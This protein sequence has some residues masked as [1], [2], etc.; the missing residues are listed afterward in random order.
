MTLGGQLV[1]VY[2]MVVYTVDLVYPDGNTC[3]T[4]VGAGREIA[5]TGQMV[6]YKL[7]VWVVIDPMGQLVTVGG[8]LVMV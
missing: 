5:D 2:M 8:H 7:M 3:A 1:I 4:V 6:S